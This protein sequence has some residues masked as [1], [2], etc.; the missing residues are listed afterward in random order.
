LYEV[1]LLHYEL[2]NNM[3]EGSRRYLKLEMEI[4]RAG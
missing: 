4:T 2:Y 3:E 1:V